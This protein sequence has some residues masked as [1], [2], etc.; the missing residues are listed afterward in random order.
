MPK[1]KHFVGLPTAFVLGL[2]ALGLA[3]IVFWL[4]LPYITIIFVGY[5][6]LIL[7]YMVIS[8]IIFSLMYIG[9]VIYY[10]IIHPMRVEKGKS[11]SIN[12]TKEVGRREKGET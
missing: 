8:A 3:G 4:L 10:A 11:Y 9:I 2:I 12:K 5:V 6:M 1:P 7:A